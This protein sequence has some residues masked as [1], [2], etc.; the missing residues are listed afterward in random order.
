MD[1]LSYV[2][3]DCMSDHYPCFLSYS[4]LH[5]V[6]NCGETVLEKRKLTDEALAKIQQ[7]L[8]FYDWS[9]LNDLGVDESYSTLFRIINDTINEFAPIKRVCV[10]CDDVFREGWFTAS[11]TKCN[12]KCRKLCMKAKQTGSESDLNRYR[13]YRKVLN[14]IKLHE[15]RSHYAKVFKKIGKNSKLLWDVMNRLLKKKV[16][17]HEVTELF[18]EGQKCTNSVNICNAFNEH[19]ATAGARVQEMI[20]RPSNVADALKCV[21]KID[22][23][24]KFDLL[25]E[26]QLCKIVKSLKPKTSSGKDGLSNLLLKHLISVIKG[27]LCLVLNKS[28]SSGIFPELMKLVK[29]LPLHKAGEF[30]LTDNFR[31]ISLLPVISKVLERVVYCKLVS[32]LD[33]H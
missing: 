33:H 30:N 31:P 27:P 21:R 1:N 8:L 10:R 32:Y 7:K 17:K 2:I 29:V 23:K 9:C 20:N 22:A 25:T 18:Y 5:S 14:R 11:L 15:K 28:L 6:V 19:F 16:D 24:F 13:N 4:L 3:T 26:G 12:K